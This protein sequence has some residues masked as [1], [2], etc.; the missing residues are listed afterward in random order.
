MKKQTVILFTLLCLLTVAIQA[1][2]KSSLLWKI[3]GKGIQT[4][5]IFGTIHMM[6]QKDFSMPQK[7]KDAFEGSDEIYLELDMDSPEMMQEMMKEMMIEEQDL[8]SNH[9]DSTEYK[10]LDAYLKENVGLGFAQFNKFK[11]LYMSSTI[12]SSFMGKQVASY[13]MTF[14]GMAKEAKK[15]L[16][17]LETVNDQMSV[18]DSIPYEDQLDELVEMLD[19]PEE[20]KE[21]Y[22]KMVAK[23]KSENIDSLY[24]FTLKSFDNDEKMIDA[25]LLNRNK[26]WVKKIPEIS[27]EKKVIYAVGAGHLGGEKGVIQLLKEEGYTVTPVL[28]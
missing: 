9:V 20:T 14:I 13:E 28:D 5:Y 12:M 25:L 4:S 11:P 26:N 23:Y 19:D 24:N 3:E 16:K 6:P 17:G 18:F 21:L 10:I 27:K 15:E 8:L 7:V 1:Q 22:G 2:E